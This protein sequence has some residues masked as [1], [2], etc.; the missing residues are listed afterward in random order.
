MKTKIRVLAAMLAVVL[1]TQVFAE[2]LYREE[3]FKSL[4][5]DN[6]A[7]RIGDVLTVLVLENSSAASSADTRAGRNSSA[8]FEFQDSLRKSRVASVQI[9]ND[10]DG[11]GTTQ[12]A[13]RL[14]AQ[15][16]VTVVGVEPNGDL[17][18]SGQQEL[19][20]NRE[21]QQIRLEGRVRT[22][23][24]ADANTVVSTR[25][26]EAKISYV[27]EGDLAARQRSPWWQTLLS[28]FGL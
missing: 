9:N 4:V 18:V 27:G 16:T 21:R 28:W 24:I 2:S 12:R 8:G 23:D 25:L 11:R 19:E 1:A 17:R 26:A 10:F 22:Q 15:I 6:K 7:Y 20:I 13:G 5:S 14:L 3:S